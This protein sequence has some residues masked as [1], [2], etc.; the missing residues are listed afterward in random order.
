MFYISTE[1]GNPWRR[2]AMGNANAGVTLVFDPNSGC[3]TSGQ[4]GLSCRFPWPG[5]QA[6]GWNALKATDRRI[7]PWS[8]E[9]H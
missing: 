3:E 8:P 1:A 5:R 2:A 6:G 7:V 9:R 4:Q